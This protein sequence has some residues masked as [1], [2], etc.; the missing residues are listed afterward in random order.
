MLLLANAGRLQRTGIDFTLVDPGNFWYG[1]AVAG[2]LAGQIPNDRVRI[3]LSTWCRDRRVAL[4]NGRV[5]GLDAQAQQ[6]GLATGDTL[7]YDIVSLDVGSSNIQ[8]VGA[9]SSGLQP[10]LWDAT[11]MTSLDRLRRALASDRALG[12][13]PRIAV[14]GGQG[15]AAEVAAGLAAGHDGEDCRLSLYTGMVRLVPSAP[16]GAA[17]RLARELSRRGVDIVF[18]TVI[19]SL[20]EHAVASR[21]G[22]RF[23]ADHVV[24]AHPAGQVL[25]GPAIGLPAGDD[26]VQ[27]DRYLRS[28]SNPRVFA[29]G[30]CAYMQNHGRLSAVDSERQAA[31]LGHNLAAV[32]HSSSLQRYRA[33]RSAHLI[34]LADG[35]GIGWSGRLWWHGPA[36]AR[37]HARRRERFLR[38]VSA[39]PG[40][41]A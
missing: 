23:P 14:V 33:A 35:S 16:A 31:V 11:S 3:R 41:A 40:T 39:R 5:L 9:S 36:V 13:T 37:A 30:S 6:V 18:N 4:H 27:V 29:S 24:L 34:D 2:L 7:D 12:A 15:R 21:D 38:R 20:H 26:G 32:G 17:R 22:R 10:R 8:P 25:L 1:G 28:P 19:D